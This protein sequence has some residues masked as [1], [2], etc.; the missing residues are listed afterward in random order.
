MVKIK[1][2]KQVLH[3]WILHFTVMPQRVAPCTDHRFLRLEFDQIGFRAQ[4]FGVDYE[5]PFEGIVEFWLVRNMLEMGTQSISPWILFRGFEEEARVFRVEVLHVY[6]T[7]RADE[8]SLGGGF[9]VIP[10]TVQ[11]QRFR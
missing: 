8:V 3:R 4:V 10:F 2:G 1:I 6:A 7:T 5:T 9:I 11:G